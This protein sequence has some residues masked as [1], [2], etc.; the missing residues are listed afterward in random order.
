MLENVHENGIISNS[1]EIIREFQSLNWI[2]FYL[3]FSLIND[4]ALF[5]KT[6]NKDNPTYD[7]HRLLLIALKDMV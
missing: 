5:T 3:I 1:I 4:Y 7:T 2:F 6:K